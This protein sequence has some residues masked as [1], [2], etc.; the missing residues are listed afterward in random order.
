MSILLNAKCGN[1]FSEVT[2][3]YS[4]LRIWLLLLFKIC[5]TPS[6]F[7]IYGNGPEAFLASSIDNQLG[8]ED[9]SGVTEVLR[10]SL[11]LS[12]W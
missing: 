4:F 9:M 6:N 12:N 1:M 8:E 5:A 2:C 7:V 10:D 11:K 3:V